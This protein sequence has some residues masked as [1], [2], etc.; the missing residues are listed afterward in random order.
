MNRIAM[1]SFGDFPIGNSMEP[2]AAHRP[3]GSGSLPW[4]FYGQPGTRTHDKEDLLLCPERHR[5][6]RMQDARICLDCIQS[7]CFCWPGGQGVYHREITSTI[8]IYTLHALM[9]Q[10]PPLLSCKE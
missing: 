3:S 2:E 8:H 6:P 5:P 1:I 10:H 7:D 9:S 4:Q